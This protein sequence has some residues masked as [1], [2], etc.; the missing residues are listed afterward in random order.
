MGEFFKTPEEFQ[1]I[2]TNLIEKIF[3]E[4]EINSTIK[5]FNKVLTLIK[6]IS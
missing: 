4:K 6:R 5:S 3:K 2:F 1:K